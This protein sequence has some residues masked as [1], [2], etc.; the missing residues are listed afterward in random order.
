MW[1]SNRRSRATNGG[2]SHPVGAAVAI[3]ACSGLSGC[4]AAEAPSPASTTEARTVAPLPESGEIDAGTYSVT[5]FTVPFE[6]TV[7][8]GWS[9]HDGDTLAKYDPDHPGNWSVFLTFWPA[10]Y[11]PTDACAWQGA[12]VEID[13]SVEAFVDAMTAQTSTASTPPVEVMVGEYSGVEFDHSVE[14]VV[15]ITTCDDDKIC[16]RSDMSYICTRWYSSVAERE[17]YRV[18]D[19]NGERGVVG[20]TYFHESIN[21]ELT[22][23]ARA[24][25][26]SIAF[27]T[28][29]TADRADKQG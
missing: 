26:D 14:G 17:T 5:A 25:F 29:Q 20:V 22:R 11:V 1:T 19:L 27:G 28:G 13:P 3:L 21:P 4:T 8:S 16:I 10:D 15:D 18:V 6:V 9:S 23:E 24:V 12:L 2:C 7:P